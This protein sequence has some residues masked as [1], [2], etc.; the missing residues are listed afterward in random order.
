V[1]TL[2][3]RY[4]DYVLDAP[5][6]YEQTV[7]AYESGLVLLSD[8]TSYLLLSDGASRI[9]LRT[10]SSLESPLLVAPHRDYVLLAEEK[11]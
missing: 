1:P 4:R 2:V 6:H 7:T 5:S 11:E 8:G 3:A 10:G 9:I